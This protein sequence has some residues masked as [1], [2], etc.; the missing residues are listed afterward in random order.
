MLMQERVRWAR[1]IDFIV[2]TFAFWLG[3][4]HNNAFKLDSNLKM[5]VV[6]FIF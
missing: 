4:Q 5:K 3:H 6:F 2:I 1:C